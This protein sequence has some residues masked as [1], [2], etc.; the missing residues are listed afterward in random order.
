MV[1]PVSIRYLRPPD[2]RTIFRQDL[3]LDRADVK[4]TLARSLDFDLEIRG[5]PALEV[6]SD[7]VWFTFPGV[8]HDIGRFHRADGTFTGVYANVLTPPAFRAG[9][10]WETTDLFLDVW[11][12]AG[13]GQPDL[14]DEEEL[15]EAER[16]GWVDRATAERARREAERLLEGGRL[17]TWPPPVVSEWTRHRALELVSSAR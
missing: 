3:I 7:A 15:A 10:V 4:V 13:G 5:R 9:G 2:R 8:W 11:I 6:G 14:L 12:P 1:T 16:E 17:G